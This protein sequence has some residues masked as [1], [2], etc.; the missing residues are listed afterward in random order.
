MLFNAII[1]NFDVNGYIHRLTEYMGDEKSSNI[2]PAVALDACWEPS[3][4]K[5]SL[6][7]DTC[8]F[9]ININMIH[10]SPF[11]AT[12]VTNKFIPHCII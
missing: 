5:E 11:K 3:R 9:V 8:D 12:E 2:K 10:I 4:W 1:I 6:R 7:L